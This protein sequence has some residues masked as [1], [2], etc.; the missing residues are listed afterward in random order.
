MNSTTTKLILAAVI[1]AVATMAVTSTAVAESSSLDEELEEYWETEREMPVIQ[2]RLFEREQ[3]VTAGLFAG[4]IT[5]EPFFHYYPV[6][7]NAGYYFRND[8]GVELSG[9][10]MGTT[11][12]ENPGFLT[13]DDELMEFL[14]EEQ[15]DAFDAATDTADRFMWRANAVALWSPFYGKLAALQQKLIHFDI[16]FAAGLG[17]LGVQRPTVDRENIEETVIPEMVLGLGAHFYVHNNIAVRFDG[18]GY[19]HQGAELP[20]NQGSFFGRLNFPMEF[21]L[22][23]SYLF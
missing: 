12:Y 21:Q 3:R 15:E 18:R 13:Q 17:A 4:M 14:R 20:T 11:D 8:L 23:V 9:A 1:F 10:F 22:G 16:N 2:N 6:G 7:A 19:L 5:S